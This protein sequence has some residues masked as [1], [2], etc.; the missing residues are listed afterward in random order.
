[1]SGVPVA[2]SSLMQV[3]LSSACCRPG[4]RVGIL[5][6][7]AATLT[8]EHLA[9]AGV[10]PADAGRRH[11]GRPRV[12]P[13][14]DRQRGRARRR[15]GR[16]GHPR[17]RRRAGRAPPRGRRHLLECTNMV[18]Y[19]RALERA[20]RPAGVRHLQLHDVVS[21]RALPRDF[22]PPGSGAPRV[23]RAVTAAVIPGPER[24]DGTRNRCTQTESME[25]GL[26]SLASR[27]WR[28]GMTKHSTH[29]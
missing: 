18:P 10:D 16:A 12:H 15:G 7:S 4:R 13:R 1:M 19:A 6:V 27:G 23:A 24:S 11:R 5:T 22:G 17:G 9:A 29:R 20:A 25:S 26:A 2:T 14:P 28:P 21:R 8:P 3:P